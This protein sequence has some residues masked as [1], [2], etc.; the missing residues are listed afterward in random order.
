MRYRRGRGMRGNPW[1]MEM[2][3]PVAVRLHQAFHGL[4]NGLI[5]VND[6]NQRV[7]LRGHP[8]PRFLVSHHPEAFRLSSKHMPDRNRHGIRLESCFRHRLN[9]RH[10]NTN[11][12]APFSHWANKTSGGDRSHPCCR[13]ARSIGRRRAPKPVELPCPN[14]CEAQLLFSRTT[15]IY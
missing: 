4:S 13:S 10:G 5:V 11:S 15:A 8:G 1:R 12:P 6:R 7:R 3:D 14:C 2:L 9:D